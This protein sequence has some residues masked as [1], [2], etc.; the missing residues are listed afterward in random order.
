M[1][2]KSQ[3]VTLHNSNHFYFLT[4]LFL[5]LQERAHILGQ[6]FLLLPTICE[7]TVDEAYLLG[8]KIYIE[9]VDFKCSQQSRLNLLCF[10]NHSGLCTPPNLI[11]CDSFFFFF[12]PCSRAC[13]ILVSPSGTEQWPRQWKVPSPDHWTGR[14]PPSL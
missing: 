11:L 4:L 14:E 6:F 12:W 8:I 7:L 1:K 9:K 3:L 2:R 10:A 5:I 13:R